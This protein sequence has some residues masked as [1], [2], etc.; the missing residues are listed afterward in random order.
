MSYLAFMAIFKKYCIKILFILIPEFWVPPEICAWVSVS[1]VSFYL[2]PTLNKSK[3]K[4]GFQRN[5]NLWS[6]EI[7]PKES[8]HPVN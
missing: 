2:D 8:F 1:F 5:L 3:C 7:V 4:E 6:S